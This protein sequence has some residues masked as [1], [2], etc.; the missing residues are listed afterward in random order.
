[1]TELIHIDTLQMPFDQDTRFPTIGVQL[2]LGRATNSTLSVAI[3]R[4]APNG[5][6]ARHVHVVETET[7]YVLR[8]V[9]V[10]VT[11]DQTYPFHAGVFVT[12]PPGLAHSVK[13][14]GTD[15]LEILAVHTPPTR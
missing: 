11:D 3:A 8:G 6:I 4:V 13:N 1:M 10:F 14:T 15:N 5:E 12:I 2:L 7:A 9:G